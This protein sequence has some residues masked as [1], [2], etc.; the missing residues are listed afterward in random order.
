[1]SM[2]LE[3]PFKVFILIVVVIVVMSIMIQFRDKIMSMCFFPPCNGEE[4]CNVEPVILK[5]LEFTEEVFDKYCNLCWIKNGEGRCKESSICYVLNLDK[6]FE[7]D[8]LESEHCIVTCNKD[9]SSLFVQ[10]QSIEK[11]IFIEC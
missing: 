3:Y 6:D 9:S 1:M 2:V 7:P 10:Y 11:K 4:E 8:D 5:E